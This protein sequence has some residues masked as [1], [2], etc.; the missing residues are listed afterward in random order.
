M[1]TP[2]YLLSTTVVVS[3]LS[4]S[5]LHATRYGHCF[6]VVH[7]TCWVF[8]AVLRDSVSV[9]RHNRNLLLCVT[10]VPL[11][12]Q[13]QKLFDT[14]RTR[15]SIKGRFTHPPMTFRP[16]IRCAFHATQ[17]T[18]ISQDM[19]SHSSKSSGCSNA[20]RRSSSV[21]PGFLFNCSCCSI[22]AGDRPERPYHSSR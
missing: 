2:S 20:T 11:R 12:F 9:V 15:Y 13:L 16:L 6:R 22:V 7:M 10:R 5:G 21:Q 17:R 14:G 19:N 18:T 4:I 8:S 3:P 1:I